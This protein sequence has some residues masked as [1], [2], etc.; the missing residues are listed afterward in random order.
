MKIEVKN[1]FEIVIDGQL[2][3]LSKEQAFELL[4]ILKKELE[5]DSAQNSKNKLPMP[6]F[7]PYLAPASPT[8]KKSSCMHENCPTCHG[9]GRD[10]LGRSCIHGIS[11]PCPKCTSSWSITNIT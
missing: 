10:S 5:T 1:T 7:M 9:T 11:C 6:V 8:V 4:L 2:L 3:S